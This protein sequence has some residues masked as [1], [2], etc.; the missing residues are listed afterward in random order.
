[1]QKICAFI[2][3]RA[4]VQQ[5]RYFI[6][7]TANKHQQTGRLN[8]RTAAKGRPRAKKPPSKMAAEEAQRN[9]A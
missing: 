7:K 9:L 8:A 2:T 3:D 6:G 4:N 5:K 1:M